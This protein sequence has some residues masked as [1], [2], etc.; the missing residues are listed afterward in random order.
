MHRRAGNNV[1]FSDGH[2]ASFKKWD[3]ALLTYSPLEPGVD[4][5][6]AGKPPAGAE[7]S[8]AE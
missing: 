1:L 3:P 6:A 2:V 4:W 8:G 7:S 5:D